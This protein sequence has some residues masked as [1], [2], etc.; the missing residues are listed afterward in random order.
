M[1]NS[2]EKAFETLADHNAVGH[3]SQAV[4]L[5]CLYLSHEMAFRDVGMYAWTVPAVKDPTGSMMRIM[6]RAYPAIVKYT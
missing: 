3:C 5:S 4:L 2:Y 1:V 6:E